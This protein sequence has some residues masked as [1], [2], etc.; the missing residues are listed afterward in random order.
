LTL[1][2]GYERIK[3]KMLKTGGKMEKKLT[4]MTLGELS[5]YIKRHGRKQ[6]KFIQGSKNWMKFQRRIKRASRIMEAT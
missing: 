4:E 2:L 1:S 5:L 6:G 3:L